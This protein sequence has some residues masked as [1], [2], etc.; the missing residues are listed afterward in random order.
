MSLERGL[1]DINQ[2]LKSKVHNLLQKIRPEK[3]PQFRAQ[4]TDE[5]ICYIFIKRDEIVLISHDLKSR[6][7]PNTDEIIAVGVVE[8]EFAFYP[9]SANS[10]FFGAPNELK[11]FEFI[12]L[13]LTQRLHIIAQ[14]IYE[15]I[16][17][18]SEKI[19]EYRTLYAAKLEGIDIGI[20]IADRTEILAY[21][22]SLESALRES[23]EARLR[24]IIG[25]N[26]LDSAAHIFRFIFPNGISDILAFMERE[27]RLSAAILKSYYNTSN[28]ANA[29]I[30]QHI[31][32]RIDTREVEFSLFFE[33]ILL[34]NSPKLS[35]I[36]HITLQSISV[37]II[38]AHDIFY[39]N[40][41]IKAT[42]S[43]DIL[44]L[45][46]L[47]AEPIAI[48]GIKSSFTIINTPF[49]TNLKALKSP[50]KA[51]SSLKIIIA[52]SH[53]K[54]FYYKTFQDVIRHAFKLIYATPSTQNTLLGSSRHKWSDVF[55]ML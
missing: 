39:S 21:R 41:D 53:L 9:A 17:F 37:P 29:E 26:V 28:L 46:N 13:I 20:H 52:P 48:L 18:V 35:A 25:D 45:D 23:L 7:A 24:V 31:K 12:E 3:S 1:R 14:K 8:G 36:A 30:L 47:T 10:R 34:K 27:N 49:E 40:S 11:T 44:T 32:A 5:I 42:I 51:H 55:P 6:G 22:E 33:R 15:N 4:R 43:G 2:K 50:L 38:A 54:I 16:A 19:V